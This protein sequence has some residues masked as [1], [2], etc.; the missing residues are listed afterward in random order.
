MKNNPKPK[1]NTSLV[2][3]FKHCS[4]FPPFRDMSAVYEINF[5]LIFLAESTEAR[6]NEKCSF[7]CGRFEISGKKLDVQTWPSFAIYCGPL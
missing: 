2:I 7:Y 1:N 5:Y 4:N 3:L 6:I